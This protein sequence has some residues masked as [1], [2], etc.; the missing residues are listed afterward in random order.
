MQLIKLTLESC[1]AD[2]RIETWTLE[3]DDARKWKEWTDEL[4]FLAANRGENPDWNKLHW[5][6]RRA[7][8]GAAGNEA[9]GKGEQAE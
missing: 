2:N 3:G 5:D 6:K 7:G 9:D 8:E 4:C 1:T